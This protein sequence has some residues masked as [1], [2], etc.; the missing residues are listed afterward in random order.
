MKGL[1]I[2]LP[3]FIFYCARGTLWYLQKFL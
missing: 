3:F 2:L 1:S